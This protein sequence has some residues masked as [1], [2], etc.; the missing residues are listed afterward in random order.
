MVVVRKSKRQWVAVEKET[1]RR[2]TRPISK[3]S[4][5]AFARIRNVQLA[6]KMQGGPY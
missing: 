4:A 3:A 2:L 6:Q 5:M 1:G